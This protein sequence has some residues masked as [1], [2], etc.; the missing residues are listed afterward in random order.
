[1]TRKVIVFGIDG[2]RLDTLRATETP[3]LDAIASAGFLTKLRIPDENP[4]ISGPCWATIASGVLSPVHK[5]KGNQ[6][7]G[8]TLAD[9]PC[10]LVRAAENGHTTYGAAGWLPLLTSQQDGPIFRP[11]TQYT[12]P[13]PPGAKTGGDSVSDGLVADEAAKAL[14]HN[15]IDVAFVYFGQADEVGHEHG[16]GD[17]YAQAVRNADECVGQVM[18]A[19]AQRPQFDTETWTY[20]AVTDHGHRDGGGHGGD[21]DLERTA[22]IIASGPAVTPGDGAGLNHADVPA[23]VRAGLST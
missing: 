19:I 12:P 14:Q 4:T 10:F 21:S 9:N 16:T 5:I 18:A 3:H 6:L 17:A 22:W 23:L 13:R 11:H 20:I 15:D 1:M 7:A 8:N 2:V